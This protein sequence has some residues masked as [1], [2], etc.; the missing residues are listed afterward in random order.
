MSSVINIFVH[1][2]RKCSK[3]TSRKK[4]HI[5][6]PLNGFPLFN[7]HP[8]ALVLVYN[9]RLER[10]FSIELF[11]GCMLIKKKMKITSLTHDI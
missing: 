2:I 3:S 7:N 1:A 8:V 4:W 9:M 10:S 6:V 5:F 11:L